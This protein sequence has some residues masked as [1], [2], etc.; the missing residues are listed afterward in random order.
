MSIFIF[1]SDYRNDMSAELQ[2]TLKSDLSTLSSFSKLFQTHRVSIL[3]RFQGYLC[4]SCP[5]SKVLKFRRE[6]GS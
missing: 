4:S 3:S 6:S 1:V 2:T 5:K